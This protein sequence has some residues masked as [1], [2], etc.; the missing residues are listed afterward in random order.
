[1]NDAIADLTLPSSPVKSASESARRV[2]VA[3]DHAD[4]RL[5]MKFMLKT[6]G[7]IVLEASNGREAVELAGS[8]F[9]D[10]IL[11][12]LSMPVLDGFEATRQ[13]KSLEATRHIPIVAVSAHCNEPEGC[14]RA[15][16]AGC[17]DCVCKPVEWSS[18]ESILSRH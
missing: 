11:M 14:R 16:E 4:I 1:M 5:M 13:I 15:L 7:H 2:L 18:I 6:K 17:T 8:S 9:P 3:E 10:L 12:D